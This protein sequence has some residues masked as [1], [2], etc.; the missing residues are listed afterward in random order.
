MPQVDK[1]RR[2]KA[3]RNEIPRLKTNRLAG[4]SEGDRLSVWSTGFS[5]FQEKLWG[6]RNPVYN[7]AQ[8]DPI[9]PSVL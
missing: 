7:L 5:L 6:L 8:P 4:K 1:M 2:T 9:A 3:T